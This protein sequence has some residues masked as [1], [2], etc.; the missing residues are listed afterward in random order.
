ML[1]IFCPSLRLKYLSQHKLQVWSWCSNIL[2]PINNIH[3][4][5]L[6]LHTCI[7]FFKAS[8]WLACKY[9]SADNVITLPGTV[10]PVFRPIVLHKFDD[11]RAV[12]PCHVTHSVQGQC[13]NK[14]K[15]TQGQSSEA[16][17]QATLNK[18]AFTHSHAVRLTAT[19]LGRGGGTQSIIKEI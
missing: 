10:C 19:E 1:Q 16:R 17:V 13:H 11:W 15:V 5:D 9:V 3:V 4:I 12:H 6:R 18:H 14:H 2:K 7:D 8:P